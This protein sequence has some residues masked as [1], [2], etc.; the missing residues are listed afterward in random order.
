MLP[1]ISEFSYGYALTSEL[2]DKFSLKSAG[3]PEFATQIAEGKAGGGWDMK[4]PAVPIYLQF[5][6]SDRMV[7]WN[8]KESSLFPSLP[9][10]RM[11]I[12]KRDHSDQ[13]KLLLDLESRGNV[14]RYAAPGFSYARELNDHYSMDQVADHSI[15]VAPSR[16]GPLPDDEK[17]YVSFQI[18][19]P[20]AYFCSEPRRIE[21]DTAEMLFEEIAPAQLSDRGRPVNREF[22]EEI[23]EELLDVFESVRETEQE[24]ERIQRIRSVADRRRP[25]DFAQL[26]ARTL[27][28]SEIVI[29]S[30]GE[31]H[32]SQKMTSSF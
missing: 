19:A 22:F 16:I 29:Y 6:R 32:K 14:V 9:Y 3:A 13:H 8:A 7:S 25:E 20:R 5:K 10:Y 24:K 4:L 23:G 11:H 2:I 18:S 15:F 17:H 31:N 12:H 30:P 26:V 1:E 21:T 27:Y 28:G